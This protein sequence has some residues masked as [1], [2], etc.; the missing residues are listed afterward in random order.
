MT[1]PRLAAALDG[2]TP[3]SRERLEWPGRAVMSVAAYLGAALIP[4]DLV[5]SVRCIVFRRG[6]LL[7][8]QTP[9]GVD[10]WPGGRRELGES[11]EE[12]ACREVQEET[13]W[14]VDA[15]TLRQLGFLHFHVLEVLAPDVMPR[16]DFVQ[17]VFTAEGQAGRVR[18][19]GWTDSEGWVQRSW[20]VDPV[21]ALELGISA[22]ER[23]FLHVARQARDC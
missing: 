11:Y 21:T 13:G 10:I 19:A 8:C 6:Q 14:L 15:S 18:P 2:L 5:T 4:D 17:V 12:T 20:L 23:R 16:L 1:D 9:H 22:A 7:V 3:L